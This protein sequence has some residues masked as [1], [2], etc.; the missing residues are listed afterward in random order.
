MS[1]SYRIE[2]NGVFISHR[3]IELFFTHSTA[4]SVF[5]NKKGQ[6]FSLNSFDQEPSLALPAHYLVVSSGKEIKDFVLQP[7][8]L[9]EESFED[10]LG[11]GLRVS[12]DSYSPS[13]SLRKRL[14]LEFYDEL[15]TTSVITAEFFLPEDLPQVKVEKIVV[16]RV[17]LNAQQIAPNSAPYD[18]WI[19]SGGAA[20]RERWLKKVTSDYA[21]ENYQ[22]IFGPGYGGGIPLIYLWQKGLGIALASFNSRYRALSLPARTLPS[23]RVEISVSDKVDFL[24]DKHNPL[25]STRAAI[26]VNDGDYYQPLSIYRHFLKA[27]GI[28]LPSPP[29]S[30]YES[31]WCSWGFHRDFKREEI[32]KMLPHLREFGIKWVVIDDRWFD[33]VG[34]WNPRRDTFPE[35][36]KSISEFVEKLHQEGFKVKL[37]TIPGVVDG[38]LELEKWLAEHPH[39]KNEISKHP[40][41]ERAELFKKHPDWLI[42]NKE[43]K[44]EVSKRANY[45]LCPSVPEVLEY[46]QKLTQK[47]IGDWDFDG[48]KHDAVYICPPC[49]TPSHN[50]PY[51]EQSSE[52]YSNILKII[53]EAAIKIKPDAVVENCPCGVPPT[54]TW[55]PYQNQAVTADPRD[56]RDT[57][58]NHKFLKALC[59]SKF[60]VLSDHIELT[61]DAEDFA[62]HIGIGGITATRFTPHGIDIAQR[63]EKAGA[64]SDKFSP[65]TEEKKHRWRKWFEIYHALAL[66]EGEYLDLYDI[67]YEQPEVHV[68]SKEGKLYYAFYAP[69]WEGRIEFRG[70]KPGGI[71]QV[72]DYVN[73]RLLGSVSK[74]NPYLE[75]KFKNHLLVQLTL[76]N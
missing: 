55:L 29:Q 14:Y 61:D 32:L 31:V 74:N 72:W 44:F 23:G 73:N 39:M 33:I 58:V 66:G 5:L 62:T 22:G 46:Y 43:G 50:H 75:V 49:Y 51:P 70:L 7:R 57:R 21:K 18:F 25:K 42:Q 4:M 9:K 15:P 68:I 16:N 11:K 26:I 27:E 19:L 41:H 1:K 63:I 69:S 56:S 52:D 54:F 76:K 48:F 60:P 24:L 64:L 10:A 2:K 36:E 20:I 37:W 53:Y 13:S 34:D 28:N 12:F 71:Y 8:S 65:L 67:V 59:G 30:S 40:Y 47:F 17:I 38:K 35:G 6:R 3:N 45:F